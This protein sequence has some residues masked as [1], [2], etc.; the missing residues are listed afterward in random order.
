MALKGVRTANTFFST[1]L[2]GRDDMVLVDWPNECSESP[3]EACVGRVSQRE[4]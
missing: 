3:P 4:G 2:A 1:S